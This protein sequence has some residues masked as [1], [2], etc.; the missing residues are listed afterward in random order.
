M[1]F[2]WNSEPS[3]HLDILLEM[4]ASSE[5]LKI[6]CP[7]IRN[8]ITKDLLQNVEDPQKINL[9]TLWNVQA[10]VTGASELE[11]L[12]TLKEAGVSV[13][14]MRSELHAKVYLGDASQALVTSANL[15][16]AGME[17]N[18]ECGILIRSEERVGELEEE[19]DR[20]WR[21]GTA[22]S[23]RDIS[24]AISQLDIHRKE[25]EELMQKLE[26]QV[27]LKVIQVIRSPASHYLHL[28]LTNYQLEFIKR[29]I[30]GEG[31]H[32]SLL[33]KLQSN[34]DGRILRLN[35]DDCER[36]HRYAT[37]YGQGGFQ[38]RLRSIVE[39]VGRFLG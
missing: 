35:Q 15:T 38:G 34:L 3:K 33:R 30:R 13:R 8:D 5:N 6:I 17:R 14:V 25:F 10:F 28:E 32:Q 31:G 21:L 37:Q 7:Y 11:S 26:K 23:E 9:L 22:I 1:E 24:D 39:A 18:L 27:K 19:F 36:L 16:R 12:A 4:V 20:E 2:I 29:P